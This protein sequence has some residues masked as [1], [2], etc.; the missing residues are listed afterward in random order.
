MRKVIA[1]VLPVRLLAIVVVAWAACSVAPDA[2]G[3]ETALSGDEIQTVLS[4]N[5]ASGVQDG[6][7][8]RQYFAPSGATTYITQGRPSLGQWS[9]RDDYYCSTW[10][11]FPS[12]SCY[13]VTMEDD[14]INF[15]PKEGGDPWPVRVL[16]GNQL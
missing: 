16:V 14:H 13:A 10:P 15:L 3:D 5:T 6:V 9:V 2:Q 7:A 12:W 4:G 8:W 11:P 1:R